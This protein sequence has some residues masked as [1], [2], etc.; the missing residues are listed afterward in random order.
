LKEIAMPKSPAGRALG[1]SLLVA[2]VAALVLGAAEPSKP[3][4]TRRDPVVE[5]LHGVEVADPYRWLEDQDAPPTREWI[6]AEN[7][8]TDSVLEPLPGR[9]GIRRRL[10]ELIK[11]DTVS[12]PFVRGGQV[13]FSKRKADQDLFVLYVRPRADAPDE[14]LLD[15][16]GL[17][18]DH[19]ISVSFEDVSIDGRLIAYGV[20]NGGQDEVVVHFMDVDTRRERT[21][22]L[23]RARYEGVAVTAD[24]SAVYYCR[25]TDQGPRVFRHV[26]GADVAKDEE[27]FG[28]GYGPEKYIELAISGDGRWLKMEAQHGATGTKVDVYVQDLRKGAP[29]VTV[30]NDIDAGFTGAIAGDRLYL[31]TNWKA[32]RFR[33]LAV[34]LGDPRRERWMEVI[35]EGASVITDLTLTGGKLLLNRLQDVA[36]RLSIHEADGRLLREVALPG[37]G[38]VGGVSGDWSQD[39]AYFSFSSLAQPPTIYRYRVGAGQ[40]D[41][42]ARLEVPIRSETVEVEQVW[43]DSKDGTKIPMFVAHRKGIR[44]DGNN[45]TLLTGYGGFNISVRPF[46]SA[47]AAFWIENGGVFAL[48]NLRG[49]GEFGE[50]W[51]QAGMLDKKQNVFDDFIAA[52]EWLIAHKYTSP[53]RLAISGGSNGGLLVGAALTQRPELFRAV[54]CAYPLLDMLRYHRFLVAGYWVPEYGSA[55]NAAQFPVLRAYSPYQNVKTDERYP[56]VLFITGDGDTRVAPLHARKMAALLQATSGSGRPVLLHY[57]TKAGHSG[58]LP[59]SKVIE[60]LTN[61]MLFLFWQ[62]G[63]TPG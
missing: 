11:I 35:P 7:A 10:T 33:V 38:A 42:W 37:I 49:G 51:H 13:F 58:G 46:F 16:H 39:E 9:D 23:P 32:P 43:Y 45:P 19:S 3:P 44:L 31:L 63:I 47:R 22:T 54:V 30:V 57:D 61:E 15:P 29:V 8:Y 5:T 4:A 6:A 12:V 1:L 52:A 2:S 62:L 60:D 20:R 59:A 17:S 36:T 21:D 18:P 28:K 40:R 14:V 55:E 25:Q 41:V 24:K 26:M 50:A 27:V 34:D 56:A 48:P 53:A